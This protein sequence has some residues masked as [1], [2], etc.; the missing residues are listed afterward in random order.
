VQVSN[1]FFAT[2]SQPAVLTMIPAPTGT[3]RIVANLDPNELTLAVE[4][5]GLVTFVCEGTITLSQPITPS[6]DV[7]VDGSN[8]ALTFSGRGNNQMLAIPAGVNVALRNLTFADGFAAQ[9]GAI[10]NSGALTATGV[11][12]V[13]N[14]VVVAGGAIFNRGMLSLTGVMLSNNSANS[15]LYPLLF[16]GFQE[17]TNDASGGGI[18]NTSGIVN[19]TNVIFSSNTANGSDLGTSALGGGLCNQSGTVMLQNVSFNNNIS[20]GGS[21]SGD[22][23]TQG[24]AYGGALYS[25]GG[26]VMGDAIACT[27]DAALTGNGSVQGVF[28]EVGAVGVPGY[29]QG[30]AFYLTNGIAILSNSWFVGN[31]ANCSTTYNNP[32]APSEGG[33]LFNAGWT[34]LDDVTFEGNSCTGA[35]GAPG[36]VLGN[37]PDSGQDGGP[38]SGG[39]GGAVY[40]M[41]LLAMTN[42]TFASNTVTGGDGGIGST[43]GQCMPPY[44]GPNGAPGNALGG[45]LANFGTATV[46]S[47]TFLN[48]LASGSGVDFGTIYSLCNLQIDTN[49]TPGESSFIVSAASAPFLA[50]EPQSQVVAA[51]STITLTALAV[52]SPVPTYQWAWDGTNLGYETTSTFVLTNAQPGESGTYWVEAMNS[53]GSETSAPVV[54]TI[55]AAPITLT[56]SNLGSA[57]FSV[58]GTGVPGIDFIIEAST[59][60]LDWQP[61]QTNPSPFTFVDTNAP[62]IPFRFYRAVVEH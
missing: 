11:S 39:T 40:N 16:G 13:S 51:G 21:V 41:G 52:G 48:N 55:L 22:F 8:Y 17:G 6:H 62:A 38:G 15:A 19:L 9:G 7:I 5:G 33:A 50:L 26:R 54:L 43:C 45:A 61:L 31:T 53:S 56:G 12:F 37:T 29:G 36:S 14:T 35:N 28:P 42:C 4:A 27:N 2:N 18:Y 46:V 57:G 49:T 34:V 58:S 1:P 60:L 47:N 32:A 23:V 10:S 24:A 30:G 25:D 44:T 20:Q 59:D 3:N